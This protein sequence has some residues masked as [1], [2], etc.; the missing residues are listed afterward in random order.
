MFQVLPLTTLVIHGPANR[1]QKLLVSLDHVAIKKEEVRSV[2]LCV[3]DFVLSP[4]FAEKIFLRV[5][6]DKA[7]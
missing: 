6:P 3:Q 7:L 1:G 5:R 4:H 2:L